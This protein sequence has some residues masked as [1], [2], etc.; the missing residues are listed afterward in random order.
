MVLNYSSSLCVIFP[1]SV[2][3]YTPELNS[4]LKVNSDSSVMEKMKKQH[5]C[6]S[7]VSLWGHLKFSS[8]FKI[9]ET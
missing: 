6:P 9:S 5:F 3:L 8:V 2:E 4:I 1:T 7:S